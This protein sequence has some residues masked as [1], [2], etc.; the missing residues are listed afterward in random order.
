MTTFAGNLAAASWLV[1]LASF[2]ACKGE[3][4]L[5]AR[6]E[7]AAAP[8]S[9]SAPVPAPPAP[10]RW[11]SSLGLE[12]EVPSAWAINDHSCSMRD[13][14]AIERAPGA[15]RGCLTPESPTKQLIELLPY[16][17]W[18]KVAAPEGLVPRAITVGRLR[19]ERA[20]GRSKDGRFLGW[21]HVPR[22]RAYVSM[23]VFEQ[24]TVRHV[25][26]SVRVVDVDH[27][28]CPTRRDAIGTKPPTALHSLVPANSSTI[29]FCYYADSDV[30]AASTRVEASDALRI[31]A[32]LDALLPGRNV[33]RPER[34]CV[35][36]AKTPKPDMLLIATSRSDQAIVELSFS[37]CTGRGLFN[38]RDDARITQS[39]LAQLMAPLHVGY[40]F[41]PLPP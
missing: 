39:L 41:A 34:E 11:E 29:V 12:L 38:G 3:P 19:A 33:D 26:D 16:Q 18:E 31:A 1:A 23:R 37:G 20:E 35:Q 5:D 36:P 14:P 6:E 17:E 40:S 30:L 8:P 2:A 27:L 24:A 32:A 22:L 21:L 28:G 13:A 7:H 4:R 15:R 10:W 25:L 9:H